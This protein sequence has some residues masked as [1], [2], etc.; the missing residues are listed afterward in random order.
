ML[1]ESIGLGPFMYSCDDLALDF[2][3]TLNSHGASEISPRFVVSVKSSQLWLE[4][5]YD[6]LVPTGFSLC[7]VVCVCV[8]L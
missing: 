4:C 5:E 6:F 3:L 2:F 8:S 1:T 7:I